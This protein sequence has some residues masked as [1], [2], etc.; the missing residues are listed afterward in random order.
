MTHHCQWQIQQGHTG[1]TMKFYRP[2]CLLL[3]SS[4]W[5]ETFKY[6]L[7]NMLVWK[8]YLQNVLPGQENSA[9]NY[10]ASCSNS[11]QHLERLEIFLLRYTHYYEYKRLPIS[12]LVALF[13]GQHGH[14]KSRG[15]QAGMVGWAKKTC[16]SSGFRGLI[17]VD[18]SPLKPLL[19]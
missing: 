1:D 6:V 10:I 2:S 4:N 18:L 11:R 5:S 14:A 16:L 15:R 7:L 8:S 9:A 12:S 3:V 19:W 13:Q 17:Q